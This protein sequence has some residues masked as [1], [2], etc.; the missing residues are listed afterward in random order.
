MRGTLMNFGSLPAYVRCPA[1]RA[2]GIPPGR[3]SGETR[4][5]N[6]CAGVL[7]A[8]SSPRLFGCC[9]GGLSALRTDAA[10]VAGQVVAAAPAVARPNSP[11]VAIE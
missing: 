1:R 3:A 7:L 10:G 8:G 4:P 5:G 11:P 9:G 2:R 6:P